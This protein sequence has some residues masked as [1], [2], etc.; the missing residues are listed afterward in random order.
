MRNQEQQQQ[1]SNDDESSAA[2]AHK[3]LID[4]LQYK[5]EF[6]EA[7]QEEASDSGTDTDLPPLMGRQ[8]NDASSDNSSSDGSWAY[9]TDND[10]SRIKDSDN[11]S[12]AVSGLQ[13][14]FRANSSSDDD[15]V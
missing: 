1:I 12:T 9:H 8:R 15:S 7:G 2:E 13:E 11:D 4:H 6:Q 3:L 14:R 5:I 10:N